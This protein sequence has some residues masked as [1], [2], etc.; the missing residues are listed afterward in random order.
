VAEQPRDHILI[1]STG[2]R[3]F[4]SSKHQSHSLYYTRGFLS[5]GKWPGMNLKPHLLLVN[6]LRMGEITAQFPLYAFM[7]CTSTDLF[8]TLKMHIP[9]VA[10]FYAKGLLPVSDFNTNLS[11][12]TIL[13]S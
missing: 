12:S 11:T 4:S 9:A 7:E 6:K 2:N 13:I 5:G 10:S 8:F 1:P 3:L